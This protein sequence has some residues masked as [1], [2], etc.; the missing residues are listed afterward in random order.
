MDRLFEASYFAGSASLS[1]LGRSVGRSGGDGMY[2]YS[3]GGYEYM[4]GDGGYDWSYSMA[5]WAACTKENK[6]DEKEKKF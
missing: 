4:Y 6:Q 1:V 2:Y 3:D 5:A